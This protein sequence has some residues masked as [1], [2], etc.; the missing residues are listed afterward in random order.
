MNIK[1]SKTEKIF[2]LHLQANLKQ[3]TN[4]HILLQ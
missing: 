1:G 4:I 3:E 2:G